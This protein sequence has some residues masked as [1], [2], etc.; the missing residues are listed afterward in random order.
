MVSVALDANS[1][2]GSLELLSL[3]EEVKELTAGSNKFS[4]SFSLSNL[5]KKQLAILDLQ[6]NQLSGELDFSQLPSE[7]ERLDLSKNCFSGSVQLYH[8][9]KSL[10]TVNLSGNEF[11]GELR[12]DVTHPS[13]ISLDIANNNITR[14]LSMC[15]ELKVA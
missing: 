1:L 8:L 2:D 7:L 12:T 4:G 14:V 5:K 15:L 13:F 11:H 6:D 3:P 9:P 10:R